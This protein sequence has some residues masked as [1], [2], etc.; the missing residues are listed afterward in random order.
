[1]FEGI[2][3]GEQIEALK[4]GFSIQWTREGVGFGE[5]YF[6]IKDGK[7]VIRSE[8]MSN[9]FIKEILGALVDSAEIN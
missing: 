3:N 4:N 9:D 5:L 8:C 6:K 1:M 7:L 2:E